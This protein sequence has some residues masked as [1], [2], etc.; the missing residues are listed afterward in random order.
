MAPPEAMVVTSGT[1]CRQQIR[2]GSDRQ[3]HHLAVVLAAALPGA[4]PA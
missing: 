4:R 3:A 2:H 1:S